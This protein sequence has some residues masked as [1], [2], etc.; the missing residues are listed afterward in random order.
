MTNETI[1]YLSYFPMPCP[2]CGR[3]RVTVET[4]DEPPGFLDPPRGPDY[5]PEKVV[6]CEKCN[7]R[8]RLVAESTPAGVAESAREVVDRYRRYFVGAGPPSL[9]DAIDDLDDALEGKKPD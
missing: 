8:F 4:I 6:C 9:D 5:E 7:S 2:V 1:Q 3:M